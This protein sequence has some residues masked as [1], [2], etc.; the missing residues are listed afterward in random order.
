MRLS[1][2]DPVLK[3]GK[4]RFRCPA[5]QQ[6][7]IVVPVGETASYSVWSLAGEIS[8]ATVR[9]SIDA[10]TPPCRWHGFITNGE[11]ETL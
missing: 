4:L 8:N 7:Q 9:P 2:L 6:H 10:T 11:I 1:E 5:C 3:G